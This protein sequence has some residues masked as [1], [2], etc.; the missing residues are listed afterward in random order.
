MSGTT[1]K[2][3]IN[4]ATKELE[5]QRSNSAANKVKKSNLSINRFRVERLVVLSK[6]FLHA[7]R[8]KANQ[9]QP[10]PANKQHKPSM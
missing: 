3:S 8:K 9:Q 6:H 5:K 7:L 1:Y 2:K 10:N 4:V